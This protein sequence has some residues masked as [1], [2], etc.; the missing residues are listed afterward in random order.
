MSLEIKQIQVFQL[1]LEELSTIIKEAVAIE[2]KKANNIVQ[3]NPKDETSDL[4]SRA[5]TGKLLG[6]S[7]TTLFHWNNDKTLP[8][9]KI[10]GR[11]YYQKSVIMNKLNNVA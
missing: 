7:Y 8:C 10:G 4:L 3:L 11:V 9:Q 5:A 2:L 1:S 6:V